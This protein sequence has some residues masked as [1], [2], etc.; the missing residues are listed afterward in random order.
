MA[1]S[2]GCVSIRSKKNREELGFEASPERSRWNEQG[3]RSELI[4]GGKR[5]VRLGGQVHVQLRSD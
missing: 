1:T 2:A 3:N 5:M 4:D